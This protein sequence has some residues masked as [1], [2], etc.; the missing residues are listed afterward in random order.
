MPR[1]IHFGVIV[2]ILK[3][4]VHTRLMVPRRYSNTSL[5]RWLPPRSTS[6]AVATATPP[7]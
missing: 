2:S 1:F 3:R 5:K 6:C 4:P 7:A